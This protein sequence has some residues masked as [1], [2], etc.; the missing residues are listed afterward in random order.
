MRS[1]GRK[2]RGDLQA[3]FAVPIDCRGDGSTRGMQ[4]GSCIEGSERSVERD[5]FHKSRCRLEPCRTESA[6][7]DKRFGIAV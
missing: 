1:S 5:F 6:L 2:K 3:G 4:G 7:T